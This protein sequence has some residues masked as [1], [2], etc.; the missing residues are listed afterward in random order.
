MV[1]DMYVMASSLQ[2]SYT[3]SPY[4]HK[5]GMHPRAVHSK[6]SHAETITSM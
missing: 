5:D 3:S 4:I 2:S 6:Y 1:W